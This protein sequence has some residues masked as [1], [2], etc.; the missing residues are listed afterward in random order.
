MDLRIDTI[1]PSIVLSEIIENSPQSCEYRAGQTCSVTHTF[2]PVFQNATGEVGY[3][4]T[5]SLGVVQG[6]STDSFFKVAV[7]SNKDVAFNVSLKIFDDISGAETTQ[8]FTS[9]HSLTTKKDC[10]I[11]FTDGEWIGYEENNY[12]TAAFETEDFHIYAIKAK[13][14]RLVIS[15]GEN[16]GE[17]IPNVP[18]IDINY[19]GKEYIAKWNSADQWYECNNEELLA[20]M[21]EEYIICNRNYCFSLSFLTGLLI[22]TDLKELTDV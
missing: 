4:W 5:T 14:G 15:F 6:S 13:T 17:V 9:V 7:T 21:E 1:C 16:G 8:Q 18:T 22:S 20:L 2:Y 3:E 10:I 19:L 11:A 12:G